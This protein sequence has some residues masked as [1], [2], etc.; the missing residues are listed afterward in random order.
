M[1]TE[2]PTTAANHRNRHASE[3]ECALRVVA[4]NH[5]FGKKYCNARSSQSRSVALGQARQCYKSMTRG[6]WVIVNACSEYV[7]RKKQKA[8]GR[9]KFLLST[10]F[11]SLFSLSV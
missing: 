7:D 8:T 11:V 1:V 5:S 10:R 9:Y 6:L 3:R 2:A 4:I